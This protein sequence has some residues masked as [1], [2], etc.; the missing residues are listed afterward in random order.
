MVVSDDA[1]RAHMLKTGLHLG[2]FDTP[3]HATAYGSRLHQ[4]QAAAGRK[5]RR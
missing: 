1:A 4:Q 5:G 3:A 2:V